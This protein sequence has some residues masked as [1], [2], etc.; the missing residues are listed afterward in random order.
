MS[1]LLARVKDGVVY[2][3]TD[4]RIVAN[5]DK[6]NE[7]CESNYKIQRLENGMLVGVEGERTCR[8]AIFSLM[9]NFKLDKNEELSAE[10]I[11]K[12]IAV[13]LFFE[14]KDMGVLEY[15]DKD[16]ETYPYMKGSVILAHKDKLFEICSSFMVL[17]YE[18]YQAVGRASDFVQYAI[19][20]QTGTEEVHE[21]FKRLLDCAA[22]YSHLVG[23]P[24][25]FI[26]T[27]SQEYTLVG[28]EE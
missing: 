14:L 28:D 18:D 11:L 24:Y 15:E 20:N 4:T 13:P 17:R 1:I 12:N 22:K 26:D 23:A 5:D 8:Q 7:L 21:E 10:H 9:D 27:K 16:E 6:W 3:A 2:L 25:L 19:G